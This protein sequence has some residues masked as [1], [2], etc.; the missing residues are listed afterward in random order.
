MGRVYDSYRAFTPGSPP[1]CIP[2][3]N[4]TGLPRAKDIILLY[5][6]FQQGSGSPLFLFRWLTFHV[7]TGLKVTD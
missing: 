4:F 1:C 3:S 2:P 5:T 6:S 7:V